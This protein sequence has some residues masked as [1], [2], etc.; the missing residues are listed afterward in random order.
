VMPD[1]L[2]PAYYRAI[3]RYGDPVAGQPIRDRQDFEVAANNLR[4]PGC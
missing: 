4:K 3:D 2:P 1:V